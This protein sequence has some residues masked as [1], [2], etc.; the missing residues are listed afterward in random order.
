MTKLD[1]K[2]VLGLNANWQANHVYSPRTALDMLYTGVARAINT[3]DDQLVPTVWKDWLALPC[4]ESDDTIGTVNGPV[5]IPRIIIAV[6]YK[7]LRVRRLAHNL[8]NLAKVFGSRCAYSNR[9]LS[10]AEWSKDHV[11]PRSKGGPDTWE[12]TVLAAKEVNNRKGDRTPE[13][14]GL[15]LHQAPRPAPTLIPANVILMEHGVR[16]PEWGRFL[17]SPA[18]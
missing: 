15:P 10:P 13:Q 4:R 5:R 6:N 16:F 9:K 7:R 12:N 1:A 2:I 11:V 3:D 14:A 17:Q 8:R 18:A